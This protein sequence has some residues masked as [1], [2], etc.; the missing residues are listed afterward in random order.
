[1]KVSSVQATPSTALMVSQCYLNQ[2]DY[3]QAK[4]T[5]APVASLPEGKEDEGKPVYLLGWIA[6]REERLTMPSP[7]FKR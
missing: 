7:S 2:G 6:Y 5:L 3:D 1:L 4:R